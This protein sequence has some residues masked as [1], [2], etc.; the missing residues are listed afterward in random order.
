MLWEPL[1]PWPCHWLRP[2]SSFTFALQTSHLSSPEMCVVYFRLHVGLKENRDEMT[3]TLTHT[4]PQFF[5]S[6]KFYFNSRIISLNIISYN[7][8]GRKFII[9]LFVLFQGSVFRSISTTFFVGIELYFIWSKLYFFPLIFFSWCANYMFKLN[10]DDKECKCLFTHVALEFCINSER[11]QLHADENSVFC[12]TCWTI[13]GQLKFKCTP[14][15]T[16]NPTC[17]CWCHLFK[18]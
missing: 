3:C 8:L 15:A 14:P 5:F 10:M 17:C 16:I 6:L 11:T 18:W 4:H 12:A 13:K 2:P 9:Y 1:F 7:S